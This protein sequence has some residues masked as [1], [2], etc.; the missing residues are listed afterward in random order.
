[1]SSEEEMVCAEGFGTFPVQGNN[2]C[3][4]VDGKSTKQYIHSHFVLGPGK[5]GNASLLLC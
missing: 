2:I 5:T 1:M 3:S 4:A